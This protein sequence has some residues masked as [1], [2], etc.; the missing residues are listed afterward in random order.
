[1]ENGSCGESVAVCPHEVQ[2]SCSPRMEGDTGEG[3]LA[4]WARG[5]VLPRELL[6]RAQRPLSLSAR[7]SPVL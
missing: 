5:P 3:R 1:M 6:P 7:I 4:N 2:L